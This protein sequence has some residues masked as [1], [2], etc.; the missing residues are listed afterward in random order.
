M[1]YEGLFAFAFHFYLKFV[2]IFLNSLFLT[3]C[4]KSMLVCCSFNWTD[5]DSESELEVSLE[6]D[7]L[8]YFDFML[9]FFNCN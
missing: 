7:N 2:Y 1:P 9:L 6:T 8:C 4:I 5:S 3:F